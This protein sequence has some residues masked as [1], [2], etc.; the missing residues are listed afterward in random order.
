MVFRI[1]L[2][3][4][5]RMIIVEDIGTE[6]SG[7]STFFSAFPDSFSSVQEVH[8]E[9]QKCGLSLT[10]YFME[11]LY[12]D[13]LRWRFRFCFDDILKSEK[14]I[15]GSYMEDWEKIECPILLLHGARSWACSTENIRNMAGRM[16]VDLKIYEDASHGVHDDARGEYCK[17]VAT[18]IQKKLPD[19]TGL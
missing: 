10:P 18:F 3:P 19:V 13:G 7:V 11:S 6:I 15:S 4:T 9:F 8:R 17:D 14:E 5:V 12:Y 2:T 1:I 16:N